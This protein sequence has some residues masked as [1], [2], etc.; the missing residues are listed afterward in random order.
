MEK[1]INFFDIIK[2]ASEN[3]IKCLKSAAKF[4]KRCFSMIVHLILTI[5]YSIKYV[6]S[7]E[8]SADNKMIKEVTADD[9]SYEKV[10]KRDKLTVKYFF[11]G[12]KEFIKGIIYLPGTILLVIGILIYTLYQIVLCNEKK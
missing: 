8:M 3:F 7:G 11:N 1:N 10:K 6:L 9:E 2:S 4:I 5:L 12:T